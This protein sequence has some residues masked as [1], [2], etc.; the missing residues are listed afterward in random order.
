MRLR[1][2]DKPPLPIER[3]EADSHGSD[4]Q[5]VTALARGLKILSC[6]SPAR[7]EIGGTQLAAMTGL[8]Q[9][10]VWRLCH[11]MVQLGYLAPVNGDKVRPGIPVLKLGRAALASIPIAAA[12]RARMQ[13][14]A[15]RFGSAC[16]LGARDRG[17]MVFVQSCLSD[18]SLV[19]NLRV[20]ARLPLMTSAVGWGLLAGSSEAE[21]E[22]L[23]AEYTVSDPRWPEVEP[24]FRRAMKEFTT[25]GYVLNIGIFHPGYNIVA[26]PIMGPDGA[27]AFALSCGGAAVTNPPAFLRREIAPA[28]LHLAEA[29]QRELRP[30]GPGSKRV[31]PRLG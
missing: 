29:L 13:E 1:I 27:P 24:P 6:F 28:L 2:A 19:M 20:G 21:R 23:I 7:A 9:P 11:T 16:G 3:L 17:R 30:A 14:L 22:A 4:R 31:G 10:T 25:R 5:F 26:A 15:D 12:A 18:A 8:P